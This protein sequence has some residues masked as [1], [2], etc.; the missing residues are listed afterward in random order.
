[1]YAV[2]VSVTRHGGTWSE[3]LAG[4]L[5]HAMHLEESGAAMGS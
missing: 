4:I 3:H 5:P 2:L 1:M